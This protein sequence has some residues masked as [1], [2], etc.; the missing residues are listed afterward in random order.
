VKELI[1][2]NWRASTKTINT[3]KA[4]GWSDEQR[5]RKLLLFIK[6]FEGKQIEGASSLYNEW[7]REETPRAKKE[8]ETVSIPAAFN[9]DTIW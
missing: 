1:T 8:K 2:P 3:L 9:A 7:V 6:R 5:K 4:G